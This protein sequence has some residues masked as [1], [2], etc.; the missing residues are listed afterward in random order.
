MAP[1]MALLAMAM[2]AGGYAGDVTIQVKGADR[3]PT[4]VLWH[5]QGMVTWLY[6]RAGIR[7]AWGPAGS[8]Q[9]IEVLFTRGNGA[10]FQVGAL[11]HARPFAEMPDSIEVMYDRVEAA[12]PPGLAPALLAH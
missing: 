6:G 12:V 8:G 4:A 2:T 5:A 3:V 7:V 1:K 11:A 9:A 10:A